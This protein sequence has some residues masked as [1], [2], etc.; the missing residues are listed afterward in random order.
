MTE[1]NKALV[2]R[3][4]EEVANRGNL[5]VVDELVAPE[6]VGHSST[7]P[8]GEAR[9]REGYRGF[10]QILRGAF[11]DVEFTIEDLIAEGDRVVSRW[12]ARGTHL[13]EFRGLPPTGKSGAVAGTS[14]FRISD[15]RIIECW[16]NADDLGLL[17]LVGAIPAPAQSN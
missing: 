15:G 5:A 2:R 1:E 4:T 3:I 10:Y 11:P 14:V 7:H 16:T 9:G 8:A 13:G 17:Q 12:Q 6:Y